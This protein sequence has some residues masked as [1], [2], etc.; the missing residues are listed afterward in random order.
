MGGSFL[1]ATLTGRSRQQRF[2]AFQIL[3]TSVSQTQMPTPMDGSLE[4]LVGGTGWRAFGAIVF[5][6]TIV[7]V[8]A[9]AFS[10]L[11]PC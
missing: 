3:F 6:S 5:D 10:L 9:A 11:S 4:E 8:T 1:V 2:R 7:L